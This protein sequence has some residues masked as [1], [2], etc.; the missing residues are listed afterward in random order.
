MTSVLHFPNYRRNANKTRFCATDDDFEQLFLT[1][2]ND[3]YRL[4]LQLTADAQKADRCLIYAMRDCFGK[5]TISR[6]F[7]RVWARRM[8]MCNAISLVL[9]I[10]NGNACDPECEFQLQPSGYR[11]EELRESAA[12]LDLP[13]VDRLAFVFCVLERFAVLDCALLMRK[14]PKN[15]NDAIV[16]AMNQ[17]VSLEDRNYSGT[18]TTFPI[19]TCNQGVV[20]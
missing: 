1:E 20:V 10:D 19:G 2:M 14:S 5:N 9:D 11:T 3:F 6:G 4:S 7:A 15:V 17:I 13:D 16:R 18:V 8:V 12:V